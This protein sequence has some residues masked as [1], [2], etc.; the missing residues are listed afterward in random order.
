MMNL[1]ISIQ[2]KRKMLTK[3]YESL[4]AR[5][6]QSSSNDLGTKEAFLIVQVKNLKEGRIL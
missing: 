2:Q 3:I 1:D 5:S 6:S 4:L